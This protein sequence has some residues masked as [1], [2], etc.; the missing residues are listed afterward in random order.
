MF[1]ASNMT[2]QKALTLLW[3]Q[4]FTEAHGRNGTFI[5]KRPPCRYR[6]ALVFSVPTSNNQ[7]A[8]ALLTA[9]AKIKERDGYQFDLFESCYAWSPDAT[10]GNMRRLEKEAAERRLAGAIFFG[11]EAPYAVSKLLHS[12]TL[13]TIFAAMYDTQY[14][15]SGPAIP[16]ENP[17]PA[18]WDHIRASGRK[19]LA[20]FAIDAAMDWQT[21]ALWQQAATAGITMREEWIHFFNPLKPRSV[22]N[23]T[24]LMASLPPEL[25]PDS[26]YISDDHL[27]PE[28]INALTSCN[29]N[30]PQDLTVYAHTNFP[31]RHK[32]KVPLHSVGFNAATTLQRTIDTIRSPINNTY[33]L[34]PLVPFQIKKQYHDY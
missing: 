21:P 25:R 16:Y 12:H 7:H 30:I 31:L 6:I 14:K 1:A 4:G 10:S 29:L 2:V 34:L 8:K 32:D 11:G 26:L 23:V 22:R 3:S 9:A 24:M 19:K 18:L 28:T 20:V 17:M 15:Y 33:S 27:V 5:T 13:T